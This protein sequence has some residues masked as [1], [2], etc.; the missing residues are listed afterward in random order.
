MAK[1]E[2]TTLDATVEEAQGTL[3]LLRHGTTTWAK[4]NRFAGWADA[5]LSTSGSKEARR[6]A[7]VL[8]DRGF[9]FDLS[10]TSELGRAWETLEILRQKLGA[11]APAP[12]RDWR[13]NERHYGALQGENR[14]KAALSFGN[15]QL[16]AWRRDYRARPPELIEDDPRHPRHDPL[17]RQLDPALLPSTESLEDA[18]LRAVP[19]WQERMAPEL[20]AGRCLLVVAHTASIR[21]LVRQIEGLS[22]AETEAFRIATCLPLVYRFDQDLK[23]VA[24]EELT[25]GLSSHVRRLL[26]KHKPSGKISW[27]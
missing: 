6:A 22:D 2:G 24:K 12:Q 5:P 9:A 13:L 19:C 17:Y 11:A 3:V 15:E 4:Q 26:N 16:L 7:K 18:A 21:G 14:A 25:S 1:A 20:A 10:L 8:A 23:V 27:V